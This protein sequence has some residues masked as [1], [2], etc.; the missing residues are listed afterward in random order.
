MINALVTGAGSVMGQSL[1]KALARSR[2]GE[3]LRILFTNSEEGGAGFLFG[4]DGNPGA[5]TEGGFLVPEARSSDYL[6]AIRE[7]VEREGIDLV[8]GG[9]E[10]EIFRLSELKKEPGYEKRVVALP[11]EVVRFTAD[12]LECARFFERHDVAAPATASY[13]DLDEFL[14]GR[15][16]PFVMKPRISSASRNI[17]LIETRDAFDDLLF[18]R[19]ENVVVQEYVGSG[20]SEYTVGCYLDGVSKEISS[21]IMRRTLARDGAS[22]TGEVVEDEAMASYCR[23]I[24]RAMMDEGLEVGPVNIQL[25]T[26]EGAPLCFEINGRFSSTEAPRAALGFNA[27]EASVANYL[28]GEAYR[29]FAPRIGAGFLRYYEEAYYTR[30]ALDGLERVG[31]ARD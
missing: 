17:H 7:I 22:L 25:R 9:T 20:D 12:K 11:L 4:R 26:H 6:P 28:F 18:D 3:D 8:F 27:L 21:I 2:Y 29:E 23:Q 10:H 24:V 31:P 19:P 30:E 15:Q 1:S 16:Y 5:R 14:S 13:A